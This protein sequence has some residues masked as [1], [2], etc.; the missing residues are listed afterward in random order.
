MKITN[1]QVKQLLKHDVDHEG[2]SKCTI[3]LYGDIFKFTTTHGWLKYNG[4]Y[5][6]GEGAEQAAERAITNTLIKRRE[7]FATTEDWKKAKL[8]SGWRSN[9][10]GT[11]AQL[12]KASE[13]FASISQF[14]ESKDHLNV[15]NGVV[16]LRSG[17]LS[18]HTPQQFFTYCLDVEYL[19]ELADKPDL[20]LEFLFS[21]GLSAEIIE[22]M[23]LSLGYSLTGHTSEEVMFYLFGR[24]RSGKGTSMETVNKIIGPL[25]TGVDME[26]F[27]SKRYGDTNNFDLAPLKNK[28]FITASESQRHGQLNPAFIKKI[29]GGDDIYC[30]FKRKDHFSYRPQSKFWLTSNFEVNTDVDDDAAWGRLRVIHYPLSFLGKEDKLLK[31]KLLASDSLNAIFAWMVSGAIDWYKIRGEGLPMP[32]E[33]AKRTKEHREALDSVSQFISQ[34]CVVQDDLFTIGAEMYTEYKS[35]CEDEGYTPFGRKRFTQSLGNRG[36]NS[37]VQKVKGKSKR[38]YAGIGI[39]YAEV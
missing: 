13:I 35:W 8:C 30:S 11:K 38:G 14:D 36:I 9:V 19:P 32:E 33:V 12:A 23:R 37:K 20:W 2:H 3:V 18:T 34:C 6:A 16:D 24:T 4:R 29:T 10:T 22:Y 39:L 31:Q 1:E 25:S 28:R 26:T 5:W 15:A 21:C 17:E 7:L 27:T